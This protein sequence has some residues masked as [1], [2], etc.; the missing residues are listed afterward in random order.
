LVFLDAPGIAG[1]SS[2]QVFPAAQTSLPNPQA[3][4]HLVIEMEKREIMATSLSLSPMSQK[5][6]DTVSGIDEKVSD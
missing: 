2:L 3:K 6:D 4:W 5:R 1:A